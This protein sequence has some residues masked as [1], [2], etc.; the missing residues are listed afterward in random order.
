MTQT[1]ERDYRTD[2]QI[3][4][5]GLPAEWERQPQLFIY[6]AEEHAYAMQK[7]DKAKERLDLLRAQLDSDLRIN[8][9]EYGFSA[10][11]T[12]AAIAAAVL[13]Q[14]DYIKAQDEL[15]D[16]YVNVNIMLAAKSG[17]ETKRKALENLTQ[18]QIAGFYGANTAP[19]QAKVAHA[20]KAQ[21]KQKDHLAAAAKKR[22][23]I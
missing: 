20:K 16:E 1:E 8:F 21:T 14:P 4:P 19:A 23:L 5:Q 2:V 9:T 12:E 11:P 7:R 15:S 3:D 10:K 17:M 6:W 18:L 13:Q 22:S